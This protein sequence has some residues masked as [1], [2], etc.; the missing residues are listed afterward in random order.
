MC[1]GCCKAWNRQAKSKFRCRSKGHGTQ[2][3]SI[4]HGFTPAQTLRFWRA[5]ARFVQH[6]AG[7]AKVVHAFEC[8]GTCICGE[9]AAGAA[10]HQCRSSN[11]ATHLPLILFSQRASVVSESGSAQALSVPVSSFPYL[12]FCTAQRSI[13]Q[14]AATQLVS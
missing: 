8:R 4:C 7:S 12:R 10:Q 14:H 6:F 1:R 2:R 13:A 11:P 9:E 3:Q 5:A